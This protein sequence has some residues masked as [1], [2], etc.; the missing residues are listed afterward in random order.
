MRAPR[1]EARRRVTPER[2]KSLQPNEF[3][4]EDVVNADLVACDCSTFDQQAV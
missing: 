1:L 3:S 4:E 2:R